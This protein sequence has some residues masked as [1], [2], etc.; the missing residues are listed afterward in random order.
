[1]GAYCDCTVGV[2]IPA[3]VVAAMAAKAASLKSMTKSQKNVGSKSVEALG[4]AEV[5]AR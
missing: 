5:E 2:A 3:T 1:M 4:R